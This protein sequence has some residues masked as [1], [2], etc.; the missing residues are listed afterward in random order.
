[1]FA[2]STLMVTTNS[3]SGSGTVA[4]NPPLVN[5]IVGG[6]AIMSNSGVAANN[7][8][9]GY[10]YA[11]T[12]GGNLVAYTGAT[13]QTGG[14]GWTAPGAN[15]VNYDVSGANQIGVT[16]TAN[17]IRYTGSATNQYVGNNNTTYL[18]NNAILNAG[19]GTYTLASGD[20]TGTGG[21]PGTSHGRLVV[22]ANRELILIAANAGIT[23]ALPIL[24]N[25]AGASAVTVAGPNTVTFAAPNTYTGNTTVSSGKA[26]FS[27]AGSA[28][29]AITVA[30]G[31]INDILLA[32]A[33]GQWV[34]TGT[35]TQNA[36]S[37]IDF[38]F[39]SFAPSTTTAPMSVAGLAVNAGSTARGI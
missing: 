5:G 30:S 3:A 21:N 26:V 37:E 17:T 27:T 22:G 38:D 15:T 18:T 36:G 31:A 20:V 16:R 14:F 34:N 10:T 24:D 6:W 7:S 11:T 4:F 9:L 1:M 2:G 8:A 25:A 39:G 32:A 13:A 33:N 23:L 35:V 12:I 29:S 19:S 28:M